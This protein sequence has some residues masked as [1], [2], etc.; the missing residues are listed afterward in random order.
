[1]S[2]GKLLKVTQEVTEPRTESRCPESYSAPSPD[3]LPLPP[4]ILPVK[5]LSH[6]SCILENL[7]LTKR[8]YHLF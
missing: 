5:N 1:M 6:N 7:A 4:K 3:Q 2:F 8:I